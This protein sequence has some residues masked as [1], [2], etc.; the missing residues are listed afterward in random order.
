MPRWV[1]VLSLV[2]SVAVLV[3][4]T[5]IGSARADTVASSAGIRATVLAPAP[6]APPAPVPSP[7]PGISGPLIGGGSM[8]PAPPAPGSFGSEH[9]DPSWWDIPGQIEKAIDTWLGNLVKSALDPVLHLVASSLLSSPDLSSGRVASIWTSVAILS[10][11][12]YVLFVLAGGI[13]IMTRGGLESRNALKEIAPRLV[14]GIIASNASL[15]LI[16]QCVSL[17]NALVAAL[18]SGPVS[19]EGIGS[20]LTTLMVYD[21]F[22][23]GGSGALFLVVIGGVI[24]AVGV[25]LVITGMVRTAALMVL[26][27]GAPLAFAFHALPQTEGLAKLWWR[28]ITGCLATQVVQAL[29]LMVCMQVFFDPKADDV[30]ALPTS[31]GLT[32]LLI[33]LVLFFLLIK[34]P[35]WTTRVVLNRSPFGPTRATS[36]AHNYLQYRA[37]GA[38]TSR[39]DSSRRR[40]RP[41]GGTGPVPPPPASPRGPGPGPRPCT[42]PGHGKFGPLP[43]LPGEPR[44]AASSQPPSDPRDPTATHRPATGPAQSVRSQ[45]AP[46]H[47][48]PV[49]PATRPPAHAARPRPSNPP[50]ESAP[51]P[52]ERPAEAALRPPT[53]H[54]TKRAKPPAA[55]PATHP[56]NDH[57][58][59]L[60]PPLER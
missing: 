44:N 33:C 29:V 6:P 36:L 51:P 48:M 38:V 40:P 30:F 50:R 18:M 49:A 17:G 2:G 21:V 59:Q 43:T 19:A 25:A 24:A 54:V 35:V 22:L 7:V 15:W 47:R 39:F 10:N 16:C 52:R 1:A 11:T 20:R 4:C 55:P 13:L 32:D 45:P 46:P 58:P 41:G 23:S 37:F 12:L 53:G 31:G 3:V 5:L 27:A 14:V 28:A 34:I 56:T 26:A 9:S 57:K 60:R 8:A 42:G